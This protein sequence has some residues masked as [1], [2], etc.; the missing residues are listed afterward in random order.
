MA[1]H[2]IIKTFLAS[3]TW[4]DFR[5][6]IITE[7]AKRDGGLFCEH[8][9][10]RIMHSWDATVHH[11]IELTPENVHDAMIALNP[12]NVLVIHNHPCHDQIHG[13]FG[14]E[15]EKGVYLVYGP[16]LSGKTSFVQEHKGN[17]DIV[18]DM[19]RLYAAVTMLP[20]YDKPDILLPNVRGAYNLLLDNIKTRYGKWHS[21]WVIGGFADKHKRERTADDLGAELVFC[22]VSMEECLR[23]LAMDEGRR[24]REAEW[25]EF[26]ERWFREYVA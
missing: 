9:K 26:I 20:D 6:Y 1:K 21:A 17:K 23:R 10:K 4:Q 13:R 24:S 2:A 14:Y 3:E 11:I 8:C 25:R 5:F 15:P 22:D 7:R 12:E 16:P 19:D 18:V